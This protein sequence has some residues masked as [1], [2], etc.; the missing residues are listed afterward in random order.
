MND[1]EYVKLNTSINTATNSEHLLRNEEGQIEATIELSLPANLFDSD[2]HTRKIEKVEMQTSKM[3]L[4]LENTPIAQMPLDTE[5]SSDTT[6]ATT[7]KL[8]VYPF[9][10]LDDNAIKPNP[11]T[12]SS[13]VPFP[14]YK[15]HKVTLDIYLQQAY[16][17]DPIQIDSITFTANSDADGFPTASRYYDV[18]SKAKLLS[19]M[20]HMMNMCAQSNHEP[21]Q[22]DGDSLMIV[23]IGTLEQMLQ[24]ALESAITYA[25]T[26]ATSTVSVFLVNSMIADLHPDVLARRDLPTIYLEEF[27]VRAYYQRWELTS[28]L[29]SCKLKNAC[30]P[31]VKISEQSITI[32]YD[33][34][35]FDQCIPIIWNT[36]YVETWD[37]PEQLTLDTLRKSVWSLPP[38]KRLY[39]YG[40]SVADS[41]PHTYDYTVLDDL[42]CAAMNIIANK[43]MRDT[44]SYLPWIEVD[45]SRITEFSSTQPMFEVSHSKRTVRTTSTAMSPTILFPKAVDFTT[46][47]RAIGLRLDGADA[48]AYGGS[49]TSWIYYFTIKKA[50]IQEQFS[51]TTEWYDRYPAAKR[52]DQ[53]TSIGSN[54]YVG[55]WSVWT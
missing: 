16:L 12:E 28:S 30:K 9:C 42:T 34:A 52:Y 32:S 29:A 40:A 36:P 7:C 47:F 38:P 18:F 39:K 2:S 35:A 17:V 4:S 46:Q 48:S 11:V 55:G 54:H 1:R 15:K 20:N 22:I 31:S 13:L 51:N 41:D 21:Y 50:D 49:A 45:T 3:R 19:D 24:D 25:L 10:L 14:E 53:H 27:S 23:N 44:F 8:D 26:E 5:V 43:T 6:K 33:T 37:T